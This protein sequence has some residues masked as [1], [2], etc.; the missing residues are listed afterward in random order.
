MITGYRRQCRSDHHTAELRAFYRRV[1]VSSPALHTEPR[2]MRRMDGDDSRMAD[3]WNIS[4]L[5]LRH[6]GLAGKKPATVP[7]H[8]PLLCTLFFLLLFGTTRLDQITAA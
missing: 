7:T 6:T 8:T 5:K 1:R 3:R 2:T 4:A